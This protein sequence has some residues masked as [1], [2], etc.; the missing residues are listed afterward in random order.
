[1]L[2]RTHVLLCSQTMFVPV[3]QVDSVAQKTGAIA[4]DTSG[5]ELGHHGDEC[6]F[7]AIVEKYKV[8]D[9]AIERVAK[10]VRGADTNQRDLTPESRGLEAIAEGF[11]RLAAAEGY[12]DHQTLRRELHLYDALYLYCGGDAAKLRRD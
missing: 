1:M 5:A 3:D 6:S 9:K 10:I 7:D 11:K 4:Y 12:D 8:K 2:R